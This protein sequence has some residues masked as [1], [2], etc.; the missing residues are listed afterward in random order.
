[1]QIHFATLDTCAEA[2]GAVVVIDVIR[3]MTTAAYAFAA[4][5][6]DIVPA[7]TVDEALALRDRFP[8]ALVMGE[9]GG[10]PVP[11]FDFGNSP[12][13]LI[14]CDLRGKRLIQRTSAGT[15]GLVRS[16]RTD[17][18]LG[19]NFVCAAATVRYLKARGATEV[20]LV[21]TG[22]DDEDQACA[23][24]LAALLREERPPVAALLAR[25]H[26]VGLM[27]MRDAGF[28]VNFTE[29]ERVE[30]VADLCCCTALD[31]FDFVLRV[32]RRADLLVMAPV[33]V[34]VR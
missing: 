22:P 1:M 30:F 34:E 18:L 31:R 11:G 24:Y 20:T 17:L 23:E 5:V 21:K 19:G 2:R 25:T 3:A 15:Q 8:G 16:A 12:A 32:E 6:R 33:P 28:G 10:L 29:A 4:G 13:A 27:R 7:G 9:V 26:D 14:G